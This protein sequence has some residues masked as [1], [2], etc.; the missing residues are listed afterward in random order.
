MAEE[1]VNLIRRKHLG[2]NV[3]VT[4]P[5]ISQDENS[6]NPDI[7]FLE[8]KIG[9]K[10]YETLEDEISGESAFIKTLS[11]NQRKAY[12]KF[13]S[14]E[15]KNISEER[16]WAVKRTQFDRKN[17][18]RERS[19]E[20]SHIPRGPKFPRMKSDSKNEGIA[21]SKEFSFDE[22]LNEAKK[23]FETF[24]KPEYVEYYD[25]DGNNLAMIAMENDEYELAELI[26]GTDLLDVQLKNIHGISLFNMAFKKKRIT[27][28]I[29]LITLYKY[30]FD[31]ERIDGKSVFECT[32]K[33]SIYRP[34]LPYVSKGR[35]KPQL[36]QGLVLYEKSF[37]KEMYGTSGKGSYGSVRSALGEDGK[38]YALKITQSLAGPKL[39]ELSS[40]NEAITQDFTREIFI[41]RT[42]NKIF[43][44]TCAT[45][46]G[47]CKELGALVMEYLPFTLNDLCKM[48]LSIDWEYNK[49]FIMHIFEELI[50]KVSNINSCGY[51]HFDLKPAN[52]MIDE[53]GY[54][55]II[56]FGIA[57]FIGLEEIVQTNFLQ[58]W[59]VKGPD[60]AGEK[61]I[62]VDKNYTTLFKKIHD[63]SFVLN[64]STD[65]YAI[66]SIMIAILFHQ[67]YP[68]QMLFLGDKIYVYIKADKQQ[69]NLTDNTETVNIL[70][71]NFSPHAKDFFIRAFCPNSRIRLT[72]NDA[73][74]HPMFN[75][76]EKEEVLPYAIT[77]LRVN[78]DLEHFVVSDEDISLRRNTMAIYKNFLSIY[79]CFK[80]PESNRNFYEDVE[81]NFDVQTELEDNFDL[82]LNFISILRQNSIETRSYVNTYR[83]F[84]NYCKTIN[85][86][87][88][89]VVEEILKKSV[90]PMLF[91]SDFMFIPFK[92]IVTSIVTKA[93]V[94]GVLPSIIERFL[95]NVRSHLVSI[96]TCKD[97]K[98]MG[99]YHLVEALNEIME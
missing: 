34:L 44:G 7:E 26:F 14:S 21:I 83:E 3:Y 87:N 17:S 19:F 48:N 55:K 22:K 66:A 12:N 51:C 57:A 27:F 29:Q 16:K 68:P 41:S 96:I 94:N 56:D 6:E 47:Y 90:L 61:N 60:D 58:T 4:E 43:P 77:Q 38:V 59:A 69:V 75:L 45:I 64:Y 86:D 15:E 10:G 81:E 1:F 23:F 95:V 46:Y 74:C 92:S 82:F 76:K 53:Q 50:T 20:K 84:K 28:C 52:I 93:R 25:D 91:E 2:E 40:R 36:S 62:Y 71:N 35:M 98:C 11:K 70:L 88:S 13:K 8:E 73:L 63:K 5:E 85:L 80:M 33:D 42:I 31:S 54:I 37:F 67:T 49:T 24:F 30:N 72:A 79:S 39:E 65:M 97:D 32:L 78:R 99:E 18:K 9:N 89:K